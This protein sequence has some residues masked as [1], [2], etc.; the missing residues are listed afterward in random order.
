MTTKTNKSKNVK[1]N[2]LLMI[3]IRLLFIIMFLSSILCLTAGTIRYT[4]AWIYILVL[5]VP[6]F[7]IIIWFYKNDPDF[8]A[9]RILKRRE[10]EK[11]HRSIQ[12]FFS[13]PL[14]IGFLIPGFDIRYIWSDVPLYIVLVADLLVLLGYLI[15]VF[16]GKENRHATAIIQI[17]KD[18]KIIDTGPYRIVRHPMY[19]GGLLL[20]LFTPLA[21]GSYWAMIPFFVCTISALVLR[22]VNEEKLLIANFPE[23]S[24]Y[25]RKTKYRLIPF[26]W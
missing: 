11:T 6:A 22:I 7:I 12:N 3:I 26:I 17:E 14:M 18:Q 15:I 19:T 23:Y 1:N 9:G 20:M 25:C 13:I 16:A 2:V 21:L 5:F 8:I 10:K 24:D 4:E